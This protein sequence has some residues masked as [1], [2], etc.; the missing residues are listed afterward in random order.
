MIGFNNFN[1]VILIG[2]LTRDP[3]V[4]TFSNGGKVAKLGFAVSNRTK[5]RDSNEWEDQPIFLDI[6]VFN[7]GENGRDADH[8]EQRL[9]KGSCVHIEGKLIMD[10][11]QDKD[12]NNR[13]KIK[14]VADLVTFLDGGGREGGGG[15]GGGGYSRSGS[16]NGG[17][18]SGSDSYDAP[19]EGGGGGGSE[20]EIPF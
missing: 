3:E 6:D 16:G 20:E 8:C 17:Y 13:S 4:R 10:Q 2:R 7:R 15:S 11:W 18:S 14:V 9:S 19:P 5:S 12:G 1:R